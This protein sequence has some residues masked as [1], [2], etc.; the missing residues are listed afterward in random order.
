MYTNRQGFEVIIFLKV[1]I[2]YN[3]QRIIIFEATLNKKSCAA[4]LMF[5]LEE[6][7]LALFVFLNMEKIILVKDFLRL[8]LNK[9]SCTL[10]QFQMKLDSF[11]EMFNLLY[12]EFHKIN[13]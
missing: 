7:R 9:R 11:E 5:G 4:E 8:L 6:F 12:I 3:L 10:L 2:R 13:C 1:R